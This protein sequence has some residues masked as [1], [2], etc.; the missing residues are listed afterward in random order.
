MN[1]RR[2]RGDDGASLILALAFLS[3][4]GIFVSSVLAFGTVSFENTTVTRSRAKQLYAADGGVEQ[5]IRKLVTEEWCRTKADAPSSPVVLPQPINGKT[6][7]VTCQTTDGGLTT[8]SGSPL[9]GEYVA[10]I[11]SGGVTVNG[12][13]WG[14][15][16]IHGSLYSGGPMSISWSDPDGYC[17][18][19]YGPYIFAYSGLEQHDPLVCAWIDVEGSLSVG[20]STCPGAPQHVYATGACTA[21]APAPTVAV[22]R[23]RIPSAAPH[24]PVDLMPYGID[25]IIMFPGKYSSPPTFSASRKYYLASGTYY[26]ASSSSPAGDVVLQ[27]QIVGGMPSAA[28]PWGDTQQVNG[29]TPCASYPGYTPDQLAALASTSAGTGPAYDATKAGTGVTLVRGSSGK[30]RVAN[31]NTRVELYTRVP[32]TATGSYDLGATPGVTFWANT[33]TTGTSGS[34]G[35]YA[36]VPANSDVFTTSEKQVDVVFHGLSYLAN[37]NVNVTEPF[38]EEVGSGNGSVS[39][40]LGGLAAKKLTISRFY[41]GTIKR[42][43]L[44]GTG[45]ATETFDPR[46]TT[47]TAT[48]QST[49]GGAPTTVTAVVKPEAAAGPEIVTWRQG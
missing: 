1:A 45:E 17:A 14:P 39:F 16:E 37:S 47:V 12:G 41:E 25:C 13:G 22:P 42:V 49:T 3:L 6:V 32:G 4:L 19:G 30:L 31:T 2:A 9:L 10:V 34:P 33:T 36:V 7:T 48:A 23:V 35:T 29:L 5:S 46:T 44:A 24:T 8:T 43:S 11:G 18:A 26:F 40:F 21:S 15:A 20:G 38:N 27:G 28:E